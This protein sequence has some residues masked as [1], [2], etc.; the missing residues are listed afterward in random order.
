MADPCE[1]ERPDLALADVPRLDQ[2]LRLG[3]PFV[4]PP[5]HADRCDLADA[6]LA[7]P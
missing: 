1:R 2:P 3:V 4:G 6:E 7:L 5:E